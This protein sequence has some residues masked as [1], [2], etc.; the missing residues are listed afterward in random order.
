MDKS[1]EAERLAASVRAWAKRQDRRSK[2]EAASL[3]ML[4]VL[5]DLV[6][7]A[8]YMGG[9]EAPVWERARAAIREAE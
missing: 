6:N 7:W 4:E 2:R 5:K 1:I 8:D 9:Y 3:Q